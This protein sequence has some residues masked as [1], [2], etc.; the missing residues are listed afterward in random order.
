MAAVDLSLQ[1][2][3][4]ARYD[5]IGEH[6]ADL[7]RFVKHVALS[8]ADEGEIRCDQNI[9][10]MH[11]GPPLSR[12]GAVRAHVAGSIPLNNEE[13]REIETW[14]A[15]IEDEYED[16]SVDGNIRAQFCIH[17][18]W[19]DELDP[20]TGVRRYRRYSCAGFVLDAYHQVR[21]DLLEIDE[22][23]LP[24]VDRRLLSLAYP[25]APLESLQPFGLE[26]AGPWRIVLAGY[27]LHS[28]SRGEQ[29]IRQR[30]YRPQAG[31][32]RF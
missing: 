10:V 15:E 29:E 27:V 6:S 19:K 23:A 25:R 5:V 13:I 1:S 32:E 20:N 26:G 11:M 16:S 9:D 17:P 3:Q 14:I 12:R 31:D 4:V 8:L 2:H 28:L 7:P 30:P 24:E 21:V 18:P 22:N